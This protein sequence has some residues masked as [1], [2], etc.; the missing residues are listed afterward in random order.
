M[1]AEAEVLPR[2]IIARAGKT[3][4]SPGSGTFPVVA[5]ALIGLVDRVLK[6]TSPN[7]L[8]DELDAGVDDFILASPRRSSG[9]GR[10]GRVLRLKDFTEPGSAYVRVLGEENASLFGRAVEATRLFFSGMTFGESRD[11][12]SS[13]RDPVDTLRSELLPPYLR[14]ILFDLYRSAT[15]RFVIHH[16]VRQGEALPHWKAV[17]LTG[18][19]VESTWLA[20]NALIELSDN[21][22]RP[23]A[24]PRLDE[25]AL[26]DRANREGPFS[27]FDVDAD[28]PCE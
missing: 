14:K 6:S 9:S 7:E 4:V 26:A 15:A 11:E 19:F 28:D 27:L 16:A 8:N 2:R 5:P 22:F 20:I 23:A 13:D 3:V 24:T 1:G 10:P 21:D 17:S 12:P 25:N 18:A